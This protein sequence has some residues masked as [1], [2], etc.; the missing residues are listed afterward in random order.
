M[1]SLLLPFVTLLVPAATRIA[2]TGTWYKEITH[3][4]DNNHDIFNEN[5]HQCSLKGECSFVLRDLNTK[6]FKEVY[7]EK[8]LPTHRRGYAIWKKMRQSKFVVWVFAVHGTVVL[9]ISISKW[10]VRLLG[11]FWALGKQDFRRILA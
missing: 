3:S 8:D 11:I 10:D 2:T 5:F 9:D 1:I 4:S 7:E 6:V